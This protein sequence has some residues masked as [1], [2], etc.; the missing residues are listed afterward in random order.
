[1]IALT[2][3]G[4]ESVKHSLRV[5]AATCATLGTV[6][7]AGPAYAGSY[8]GVCESSNGGEVCLHKEN[9]INSAVYDTLYSKTSYAGSTFY[10]TSTPIDNNTGGA[11]NKDPDNSVKLFSGQNYTG[12]S[13][14]VASG[15]SVGYL[16]S[17][18]SV[19]SHCFTSNTACP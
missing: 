4:T 10:G 13:L 3:K 17:Y 16:K 14:S 18:Y 7:I 5:L 8:N 2:E 6:V 15:H 12:I 1:M 9:D 11:E 19:S